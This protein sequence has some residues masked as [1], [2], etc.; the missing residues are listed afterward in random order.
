MWRNTG[1]PVRLLMLDARACLPILSVMVY[2]SWLTLYIAIIGIVFFSAISFFGLTLPAMTR[3]AR[4]W[5][6]G[7]VRT[8]VPV[9][10]RRRL[11]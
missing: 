2:W 9:W 5:L 10:N 8:A 11:A 7:P 4:R 1:Q 6:V 3:L